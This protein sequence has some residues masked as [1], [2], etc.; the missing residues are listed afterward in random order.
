M[1]TKTQDQVMMRASTRI[2]ASGELKVEYISSV[3]VF[4]ATRGDGEPTS[5][6]FPSMTMVVVDDLAEETEATTVTGQR[7][8]E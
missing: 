2:Q 6:F 3:N 5:P 1:M 4:L 8:K 7:F